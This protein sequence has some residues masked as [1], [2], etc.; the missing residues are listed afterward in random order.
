MIERF[1]CFAATALIF[2]SLHP[3]H[4]ALLTPPTNEWE[5]TQLYEIIKNRQSV[6]VEAN[7][8]YVA[9][10]QGSFP[11]IQSS[12][13]LVGKTEISNIYSGGLPPIEGGS[14]IVG[15]VRAVLHHQAAGNRLENLLQQK[16]MT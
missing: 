7:A 15:K 10:L 4:A 2:L 5:E 3:A 6:F 9:S 11:Q 13:S 12:A 14:V 1:L 8:A 16:L